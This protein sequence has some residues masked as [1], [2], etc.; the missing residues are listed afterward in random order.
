VSEGFSLPIELDTVKMDDVLAYN[1]ACRIQFSFEN[2][3]TGDLV[4]LMMNHVGPIQPGTYDIFN[5]GKSGG[6]DFDYIEDS[7]GTAYVSFGF[8]PG[9]GTT[10]GFTYGYIGKG[11]TV[12]FSVVS[13]K[14]IR[15][16]MSVTG[17]LS[18]CLD[19]EGHPSSLPHQFDCPGPPGAGT[20]G[21]FSFTPGRDGSTR[22][23]AACFQ[24][25][26]GGRSGP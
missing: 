17:E 21:Q 20:Q 10:N 4:A 24:T 5:P 2:S 1:G 8:G 23:S 11:G 9:N 3:T 12:E 15:G 13:P 7:P 19:E 16:R 14:L 6:F 26:S 25:A 22:P 18:V